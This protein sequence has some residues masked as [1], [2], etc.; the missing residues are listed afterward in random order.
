M[1]WKPHM[2]QD[3]IQDWPGRGYT[4]TSKEKRKQIISNTEK[5][6]YF[7]LFCEMSSVLG[8]RDVLYTVSI[9]SSVLSLQFTEY[10]LCSHWR[11]CG[12]NMW[13]LY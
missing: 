2:K 3:N 11:T 13:T 5:G 4:K 7:E 6:R 12:Q 9:G 8:F 10:L 1:K